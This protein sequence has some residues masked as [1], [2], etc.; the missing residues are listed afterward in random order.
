V[1][2]GGEIEHRVGLG[3]QFFDEF[4]VANVPFDELVTRVVKCAV[5]ICLRSRVG[6]GVE[7]RDGVIQFVES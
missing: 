5:E 1:R 2:L 6:Q 4:P 7:R 3:H